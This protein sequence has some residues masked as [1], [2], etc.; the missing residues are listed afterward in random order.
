MHEAEE[1]L[2][3]NSNLLVDLHHWLVA[4]EDGAGALERRDL[5]R[6]VERGDDADTAVPERGE[7]ER[8][9]ERAWGEGQR[10]ISIALWQYRVPQWQYRVKTS[11]GTCGPVDV[12]SVGR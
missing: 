4:H 2:E 8:E 12:G 10:R 9:R 6:E 11:D 5:K 3:D 1:L 7:R